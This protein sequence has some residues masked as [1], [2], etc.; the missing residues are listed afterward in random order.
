[1]KNSISKMKLYKIRKIACDYSGIDINYFYDESLVPDV[2]TRKKEYRI[3]R[4]LM[5]YFLKK[6]TPWSLRLIGKSNY[7]ISHCNVLHAITVVNNTAETNKIFR[8]E[9]MEMEKKVESDLNIY[10]AA[11]HDK[12]YLSPKNLEMQNRINTQRAEIRQLNERNAKLNEALQDKDREIIFL[13]KKMD[14]SRIPSSY[15]YVD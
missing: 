10:N 5:C 2:K 3:A 9:L 1:M 7:G 12:V 4:Q 14:R 11:L 15:Q 6:Y 8:S 13:K